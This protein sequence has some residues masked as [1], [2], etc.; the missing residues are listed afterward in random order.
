[1]YSVARD[2]LNAG[3]S[4][5][6]VGPFTRELQQRDWTSDDG[7]LRR[8]IAA[9]TDVEYT[10]RVFYVHCDDA[11]RRARMLERANPRDTAKL[12]GDW[13]AHAE[14][15]QRPAFDSYVAVDSTAQFNMS[16]Y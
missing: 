1:M 7:G 6:L 4:V 8:A 15:Y 5:V 10:V 14:R 12:T 11:L 2:N 9:N 13:Q 3:V 16:V